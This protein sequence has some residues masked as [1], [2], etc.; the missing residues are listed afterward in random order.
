MAIAQGMVLASF[1]LAFPEDEG[2]VWRRQQEGWSGGGRFGPC[3]KLQYRSQATIYFRDEERGS[4]ARIAGQA[5]RF[6]PALREYLDNNVTWVPENRYGDYC[7]GPEHVDTVI[8]IL[9]NG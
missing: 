6:P 3:R 2:W 7:I 4:V 8:A 1:R 9:R 5:S